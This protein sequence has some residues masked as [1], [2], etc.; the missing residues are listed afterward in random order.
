MFLIN[1]V[2]IEETALTTNPINNAHLSSVPNTG[3]VWS[4]TPA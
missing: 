2:V 1:L 3:R 4:V